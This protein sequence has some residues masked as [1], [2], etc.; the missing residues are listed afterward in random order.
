MAKMM[1]RCGYVFRFNDSTEE[2]EQCLLHWRFLLESAESL[3]QKK[4]DG[5]EFFSN[6]VE[7][8]RNAHPCPECGRIYIE[9]S[10]DSNEYDVY[11][12]EGKP[13]S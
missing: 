8:G 1:C 13:D 7:V 10:A 4:I 2:H 11:V 3:R 6:C 12:K 9:T 5:S